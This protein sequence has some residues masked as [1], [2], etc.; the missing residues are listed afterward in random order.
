MLTR[1]LMFPFVIAVAFLWLGLGLVFAIPLIAKAV[2]FFTIEL[3]FAAIIQRPRSARTGEGLRTALLFY[4]NGFRIIF[5]TLGPYDEDSENSDGPWEF[6]SGFW[7]PLFDVIRS[8]LLALTFWATTALFFH[9]IGIYRVELIER[10]ERR[11]LSAIGLS[12]SGGDPTQTTRNDCVVNADRANLRETASHTSD[13]I[14]EL[15]RG[16]E[17]ALV[18]D[19]N[20]GDSWISVR[21]ESGLSGYIARSLVLCRSPPP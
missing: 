14:T 8:I 12:I 7:G 20:P 2:V 1:I 4:P 16:A 21:S 11:I 13:V 5:G 17:L 18:A 9:H 19:A 10:L 3:L 6:S 15:D